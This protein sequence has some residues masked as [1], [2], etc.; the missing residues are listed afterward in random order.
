MSRAVTRSLFVIFKTWQGSTQVSIV[1]IRPRTFSCRW[2]AKEFTVKV[3]YCGMGCLFTGSFVFHKQLEP[4]PE[5]L[6][7]WGLSSAVSTQSFKKPALTRIN[8]IF[9]SITNHH[10]IVERGTRVCMN[11]KLYCWTYLLRDKEYPTDISIMVL[12][13][14]L[15]C[16]I[17]ASP[18]TVE[19]CLKFSLSLSSGKA[20]VNQR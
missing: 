17:L 1:W 8:E 15:G 11:D 6:R 20:R 3:T 7:L 5:P 10:F 12:F 9:T 16:I 18:P 4:R 14:K 13:L 19:C 2:D